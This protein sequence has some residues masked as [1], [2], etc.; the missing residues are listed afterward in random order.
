[1]RGRTETILDGGWQVYPSG[2]AS[3]L[4]RPPIRNHEVQ[5]RVQSSGSEDTYVLPPSYPAGTFADTEGM[6]LPLGTTLWIHNRGPGT[7]KVVDQHG[8]AMAM[9]TTNTSCELILV[10]SGPSQPGLWQRTIIVSPNA[11]DADRLEGFE[12]TL[13]LKR[14][15]NNVDVLAEAVAAGYDGT[16]P[17]IVVVRVKAGVA[18]GSDHPLAY[19]IDMGGDTAVSGINWHGSSTHM[20][21]LEAGAV[22]GGCGGAGGSGGIG[23]TGASTGLDGGAGGTAVRTKR[24]LLV[25]NDGT[26]LGGGGGG[27]GGNGSLTIAGV[28]GGPGGGG[29]GVTVQASGDVVGGRAGTGIE[30]TGPAEGGA[31]N[32]GG[33]FGTGTTVS[34]NTGGR[35]GAGGGPATAG[36]RGRTLNDAGNGSLGGAAGAAFS[37][38]TSATITFVA[39]GSGTVSGSTIVE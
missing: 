11:K 17:A 26:V 22:V 10:A 3:T 28:H 4:L 2:V 5:A 8:T 15:R 1:M 27:G 19:S 29:A 39:G 30:G 7:A 32:L 18:I 25:R 24:D 36:G 31:T 21:I 6:R 33:Q 20:L 13:D 9:L 37:R 14:S 16:V 34:P 12:F 38:H 35:G 23:G